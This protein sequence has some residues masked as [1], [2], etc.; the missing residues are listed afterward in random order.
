MKVR[1]TPSL[2]ALNIL[3]E[4]PSLVLQF[5]ILGQQRTRKVKEFQELL[6]LCLPLLPRTRFSSSQPSW[7]WGSRARPQRPGQLKY[8]T[9]HTIPAKL[10]ATRAYSMGKK[11][12]D[13]NSSLQV[14][15][16]SATYLEADCI[17]YFNQPNVMIFIYS[18]TSF[19]NLFSN[20]LRLQNPFMCEFCLNEQNSSLQC[21]DSSQSLEPLGRK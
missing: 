12:S 7:Q 9:R 13:C 11:K 4:Q 5:C 1:D 19:Q 14:N 18:L 3:R 21:N 20:V 15:F 16:Q 2:E 10:S 8:S 6:V 17:Y